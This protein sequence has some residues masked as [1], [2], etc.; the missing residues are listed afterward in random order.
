MPSSAGAKKKE[1][2]QYMSENAGM[3]SNVPFVLFTDVSEEDVS[4]FNHDYDFDHLLV[5]QV[6]VCCHCPRQDRIRR[7]L[8]IEFFFPTEIANF[9]R[10]NV[11][12]FIDAE[13]GDKSAKAL[14]GDEM[15][16]GGSR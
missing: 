12:G 16:E 6:C 9:D 1:K 7:L 5:L 2:P 13:A 14:P 4:I 3:H 10:I 11:P 15:H 8:V